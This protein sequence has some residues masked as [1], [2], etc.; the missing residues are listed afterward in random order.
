MSKDWFVNIVLF[1]GCAY[2]VS[3]EETNN[4]YKAVPLMGCCTMIMSFDVLYTPPRSKLDAYVAAYKKTSATLKLHLELFDLPYR[5]VE[6][7]IWSHD[8]AKPWI[9]WPLLQR[10][11]VIVE[12]NMHKHE[13]D[14]LYGKE[15]GR[16]VSTNTP[17]K[18]HE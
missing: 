6:L 8:V 15:P 10:L 7:C 17:C 16:L 1:R 5:D 13:F 4:D 3:G 2:R 11:H 14:F 12:K 18:D 9:L